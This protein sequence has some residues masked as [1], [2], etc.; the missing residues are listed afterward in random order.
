MNKGASSPIGNYVNAVIACALS[1]PV[2]LRVS[3]KNVNFTGRT[4][5]IT[6]ILARCLFN[7]A[8]S[9]SDI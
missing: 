1:K 2:L 8:Q 3:D 9:A 7:F 6:R 4:Y 5:Q